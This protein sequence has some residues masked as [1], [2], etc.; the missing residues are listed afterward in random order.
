MPIVAHHVAQRRHRSLPV[1]ND[2]E[3]ISAGFESVVARDR[4]IRSGA[5][6]T[7]AIG[8]VATLADTRVQFFTALSGE[9]ETR[10]E[11]DSGELFVAFCASAAAEMS[12]RNVAIIGAIHDDESTRTCARLAILGAPAVQ[13]CIQDDSTI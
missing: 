6:R 10:T 3:H 1:D 9:F 8:H 5:G 11:L 13:I 4:R 2:I 7:F 12:D